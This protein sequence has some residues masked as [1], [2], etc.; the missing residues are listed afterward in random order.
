MLLIHFFKITAV[1]DGQ[2]F[3]LCPE[4]SPQDI[5]AFHILPSHLA[6]TCSPTLNLDCWRLSLVVISEVS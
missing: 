6:T 3:V 1:R 5:H 4:S 2:Q